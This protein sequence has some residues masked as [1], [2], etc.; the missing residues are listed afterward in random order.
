MSLLENNRAGFDYQILEKLEAGIELFGHEVKSL[1]NKLGSLKG[2]RVVARGGEA[3][4][5]GATIPAWQIPNAPKGFDA[6]R[7]RRLLL[8]KKEIAHISSAESEKGLTIIPLSVYN[9]QRHL[10]LSLAIVRGKKSHDKRNT[11]R[12]RDEKRR[13]QR[14]LKD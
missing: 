14:T 9:K 7:P 10:K 13:M 2:A 6:E 12:E 5:V 3:Y 4:L 8:N 1:R 11:I